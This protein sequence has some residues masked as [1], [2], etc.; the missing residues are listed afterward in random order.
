MGAK[1][2]SGH[3]V[4]RMTKGK[5]VNQGKPYAKKAQAE[6]ERNSGQS[7]MQFEAKNVTTDDNALVSF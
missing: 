4:Q 1:E 6:K 2:T 7:S 3:Q 5:F